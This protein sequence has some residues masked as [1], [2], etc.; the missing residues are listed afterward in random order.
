M[1]HIF[2]YI[3]KLDNDTF[4][5]GLTGDLRTRMM[6]HANGQ[7]KS[8]REKLPIELIWLNESETRQDARTL[9]VKIKKRGAKRFMKTYPKGNIGEIY[10]FYVNESW[11]QPRQS[12][13]CGTQ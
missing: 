4:Y 12:L 11:C 5:T 9:E 8:T 7:S 2:T 13:T 6:T 1:E 10:I 3:L